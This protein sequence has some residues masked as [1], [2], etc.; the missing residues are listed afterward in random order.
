[1]TDALDGLS[2]GECLLVLEL[3][4]MQFY[5]DHTLDFIGDNIKDKE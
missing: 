5:T 1:M 4:K 2:A 3:K